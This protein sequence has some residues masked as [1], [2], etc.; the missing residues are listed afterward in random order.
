MYNFTP[1]PF[2]GIHAKFT[3]EGFFGGMISIAVTKEDHVHIDSSDV[4]A[5]SGK[6]YS[7]N[8]HFNVVGGKIVP[9][10]DGTYY[11]QF[12]KEN[13]MSFAPKTVQAY[14]DNLFLDMATEFYK[15]HPEI[16]IEQGKKHRQ[17]QILK[18]REDIQ[19]L[20]EQIELLRR[21]IVEIQNR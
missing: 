1:S 11:L 10:V 5:K 4:M 15:Q 18:K 14:L 3:T 6:A 13:G 16:F 21:S 20:Q 2:G 12:A 8:R 17:R 19:E 7:F 9:A